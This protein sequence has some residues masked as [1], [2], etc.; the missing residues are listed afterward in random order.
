[1]KK[2]INLYLKTLVW[3]IFL[4]FSFKQSYGQCTTCTLG[5]NLVTG[6]NFES[7]CTQNFE[8]DMFK[9]CSYEGWGIA[10]N[11]NGLFLIGKGLSSYGWSTTTRAANGSNT[12]SGNYFVGDGI[13]GSSSAAS[14]TAWAQNINVVAGKKYLFS[15][16]YLNQQDGNAPIT[17]VINGQTL[18]TSNTGNKQTWQRLCGTYYPSTTGT[19]K[20]RVVKFSNGSNTHMDNDFGLDD[21]YFGEI[22]ELELVPQPDQTI[23][24]G[25]L[26]EL[27]GVAIKG[28]GNYSYSWSNGAT[29]Q[30]VYVNPDITTTYTVLIK[31]NVTNCTVTDEITV[32]VIDLKVNLGQDI[33]ICKTYPTKIT[34]NVTGGSGN[35][36]YLWNTGE[37][38]SSITVDY[39]HPGTYN[40]Q[41]KDNLHGCTATDVIN[42][43]QTVCQGIIRY[44][45]TNSLPG[46][47]QYATI[48][49]GY[50]VDVQK[51][52]GN[53]Y[54]L[55]GQ[56]VSF[57]ANND[58]LLSDGFEVLEDGIFRAEI[59]E[60]C[61]LKNDEAIE[62]SNVTN[63]T[64]YLKANKSTG[65][66]NYSYVWST[67]GTDRTI[68]VSPTTTA[69]YNVTIKDQCLG[70]SS[71]ASI[72]FTP[73]YYGNFT[74]DVLPNLI[75]PNGDG[76]ND[77]WVLPDGGKQSFAYNATFYSFQVANR[78]GAILWTQSATAPIGSTGFK[79]REIH[80]D[81]S[82]YRSPDGTYF[83]YLRLENCNKI[84]E[85]KDWI[86]IKDSRYSRISESS[87]T[88]FLSSSTVTNEMGISPN[89]SNG[90]F[91]ITSG[92]EDGNILN[93]EIYDITGQD[94]TNKALIAIEDNYAEIDLSFANPGIYMVKYASQNKV[95]TKEVIIAR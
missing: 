66:G 36:N 69:T 4:M 45:N 70:N 28:S 76:M 44:Q 59:F 77:T 6:G 37:T 34:A 11:N 78:W 57:E 91:F 46:L 82:A 56:N 72:T 79:D 40:L 52:P 89:P 47:T 63:C 15:L 90:K 12:G 19:V 13:W 7:G 53:V 65:S 5:S 35:Y 9:R 25:V 14:N 50:N 95:I 1:M 58:I 71:S 39:Y 86:E 23:C 64:Y 42:A 21:I 24:K 93:L 27:K 29:S 83:Y 60:N 31:D 62:K 33:R 32:N 88:T 68:M 10:D 26:V 41:V 49:A 94:L 73:P 22:P 54:V 84:S 17:L 48:E 51:T 55:P 80:W 8:S 67:G 87:D 3:L 18:A 81:P 2:K 20:I 38:N 75:T 30:S 16:Y 74:Y 85:Y 92:S 43:S 61:F